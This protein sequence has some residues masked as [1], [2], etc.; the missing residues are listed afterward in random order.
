MR[1]R[2]ASLLFPLVCTPSPPTE[3]YRLPVSS[4]GLKQGQNK[5]GHKRNLLY[6][7]IVSWHQGCLHVVGLT[8]DLQLGCPLFNFLIQLMPYM[9]VDYTS[10]SSWLPV[11]SSTQTAVL[12]SPHSFL[13]YTFEIIQVQFPFAKTIP[14]T[15]KIIQPYIA[16][17]ST[18]K[19]VS[20]HSGCYNKNIINWI[21]YEQQTF[22][23]YSFKSWKVQGHRAGRYST[24]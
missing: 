10:L 13:Q 14:G 6:R 1:A 17:L 22:I 11:A 19:T 18:C 7:V 21:P 20:I 15:E 9:L 2:S 4:L 16:N 12:G 23:S 3:G 24:W 8:A 5:M